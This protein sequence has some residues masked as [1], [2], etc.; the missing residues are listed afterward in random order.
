MLM[1]FLHWFIP[2]FSA[3][4]SKIAQSWMFWGY[5]SRCLRT[6]A[7]TVPNF[8]NFEFFVKCRIFVVAFLLVSEKPKKMSKKNSLKK[9]QKN[10]PNIFFFNFFKISPKS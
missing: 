8:Q 1:F 6:F 2:K 3:Q 4:N 9:F 10:L 5:C 7:A